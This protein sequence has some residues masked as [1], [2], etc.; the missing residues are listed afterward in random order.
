M[1]NTNSCVT[2]IL[3][4]I[5]LITTVAIAETNDNLDVV[6]N[7]NNEFALDLY[8]ELK[9][10]RG[11]LFFSPYS[12]STA[13]A[14]TYAGARGQTEIEMADVLRFTL[15]QQPLHSAFSQLQS[16]L[17]AIRNKGSIELS[18]AN[19]LWAQEGY[20]FL[21][22]FFDLNRTTYGA[23]LHFVDY[24]R[25]TETARITINAWV[26]D[27]THQKIKEIIKPGM[28]NSGTQLV[29]CNAIY[30][31]GDWLYQFDKRRTR[32][33]DFHV[34][35]D[36]TIKVPMMQQLSKF[37]FKDF[38]SFS[39]IEFPYEGND[40][41]MVIFL[42]QNIDGL[43]GLEREL[44]YDNV[45]NWINKLSTS[46]DN[47]VLVKLPKFTTTQEL[48]LKDYLVTMGMTHVFSRLADFSGM[49]G[50]RDLFIDEVIHKA[51]VDVNEKGTEAA[52]AT[53]VGVKTVSIKSKGPL[54]FQADHPFV[55]LIRDNITGSILFIGRIIDPTSKM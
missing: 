14:M 3:I 15:D 37:K 55:F 5:F 16:E 26:E 54:L 8:Q 47:E 24:K 34:S 12:I 4:V 53:V 20:S 36:T 44:T 32:D 7:S 23:G 17:N 40:L 25:D 29:L 18:V 50:K 22:S 45:K 42:P 28:I 9:G 46:D 39:A 2:I 41:S 21:D 10:A 48:E 13:L 52:A 30:F 51:F 11:N 31:L 1:K 38:G 35:R 43:A 6:V 19:S 49:T 33:A 27:K